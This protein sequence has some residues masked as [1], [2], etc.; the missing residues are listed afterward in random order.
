ME[1]TFH[2][3]RPS[4]TSKKPSISDDEESAL[5]PHRVVVVDGAPPSS[6][7]SADLRS[8]RS[9]FTSTSSVFLDENDADE[10]DTD[11]ALLNDTIPEELESPAVTSSPKQRSITSSPNFRAL[12]GSEPANVRNAIVVDLAAWRKN[13]HT[14]KEHSQG[15]ISQVSSWFTCLFG[16]SEK[17]EPK[18]N[19]EI[20]FEDI[21]QLKWIGSG[22]HGCVFLGQYRH[23]EVAVKKFREASSILNE[24]RHLKELSH[25]NIV[26]LKGVCRKPPVFCLVME[27]CPKS[28]YDVIQSTRIA[29]PLALDWARQVAAGMEYLHSCNIIHRDLKSPNVLVAADKRTLKITDFGTSTDMPLR[30][31]KM[32]FKGTVSWMSPELLRGE[33]SGSK[34]D[35]YS[36]GVVLWEL[37]SGETPFAGVDVGAVI[38]GVGSGRMH[39]PIPD[40]TPDGFSLLMKQCWNKAAKHRPTFRQIATHL[41]ILASDTT[42]ATTPD[43][44]YFQTQ[45]RWKRE[46]REK[47]EEMKKAEDGVRKQN[48]ELIKRREVELSHIRDVRELYE[49]RLAEVLQLHAEL[50]VTLDRVQSQEAALALAADEQSRMIGR[51]GKRGNKHRGA[52]GGTR[53]RRKSSSVVLRK[54]HKQAERT[55]KEVERIQ[56]ELEQSLDDVRQ[57]KLTDLDDDVML[58]I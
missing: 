52:R 10:S 5:V 27:Y 38:W 58:N 34:V 12:L 56:H 7:L 1:E 29:A 24:E 37:L 47:F 6:R 42:F 49:T 36:F 33:K 57:L 41:D 55:H 35:V 50:S 13:L 45:L 30:S 46:I 3:Y 54:S 23:E 11:D 32:S 18:E 31:T 8:R 53:T 44:S 51:K 40:G 26:A 25:P 16:S 48:D 14:A 21:R 17:L 4:T 2:E 19:F 43:E 22:A 20:N 9:T 39:L 28:L 15:A